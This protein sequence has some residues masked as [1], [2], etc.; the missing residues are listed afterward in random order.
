MVSFMILFISLPFADTYAQSYRKSLVRKNAV[1]S[2]SIREQNARSTQN[3]QVANESKIQ[4]EN[5][6]DEKIKKSEANKNSK[7]QLAN[8]DV[9]LTVFADGKNKAEAIQAA[10]RSAIEQAFGVFVSSH[11]EILNDSLVKDEV[12][13]IASGNIKSFECLSENYIDDKC[14]VNVRAIVSTNNL[15]NYTKSKGGSAELAGSI[16]AMEMKL[17]ELNRQNEIKA[18]DHLIFQLAEIA[19]SLF[20][21]NLILDNPKKN[22]DKY[23]CSLTII[24]T[25]N[26][27]AKVMYDLLISTLSA[28]SMNYDEYINYCNSGMGGYEVK[29]SDFLNPSLISYLRVNHGNALRTLDAWLRFCSRN[30]KLIDNFGEYEN[31][32]VPPH[33]PLHRDFHTSSHFHLHSNHIKL[34]EKEWSNLDYGKIWI[35]HENHGIAHSLL[36]IPITT[37][38]TKNNNDSMVQP[39]ENI[40]KGNITFP[41][42][43]MLSKFSSI[44]IERISPSL[45]FTDFKTKVIAQ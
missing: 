28:L 29:V 26:E 35:K 31:E 21:F 13:T 7:N 22:G 41:D 14:L 30:F 24:C 3:Q 37:Q 9:Q 1:R 44:R 20:N 33:S 15:I 17:Q 8:G 34:A 5:K 19:P 36:F 43:N 11:T 38:R 32:F 45:S 18:I 12:A 23:E 39:A 42:L 4:E 25:I 16:F 6:Q 10:L 40:I 2:I 27:N